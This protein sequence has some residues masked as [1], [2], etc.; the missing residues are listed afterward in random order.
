MEAE[1][2]KRT[3][4][5]VMG[6]RG[7]GKTTVINLLLDQMNPPS[8]RGDISVYTGRLFSDISKEGKVSADLQLDMWEL[9]GG[10]LLKALYPILLTEPAIYLVLVTA[11]TH[12]PDVEV[13]D[14]CR[15]IMYKIN[16]PRIIVILTK[17]N[18]TTCNNANI[19]D[20]CR[21]IKERWNEFI[22]Q[23]CKENTSCDRLTLNAEVI[24]DAETQPALTENNCSLLVYPFNSS[25]TQVLQQ[26][27]TSL[28]ICA[29]GISSDEGYDFSIKPS[30]L[31]T[32]QFIQKKRKEQVLF[33]TKRQFP[34]SDGD[35][36]EK[37]LTYLLKKD[38]V[39]EVQSVPDN[40]TAMVICVDPLAFSNLLVR[41]HLDSGGHVF[42]LEAGKFW[43]PNMDRKPPNPQVLADVLEYLQTNGTVPESFLPLLWKTPYIREDQ[44]L[45]TLGVMESLGLI[46]YAN[47][48]GQ[49]VDPTPDLEMPFFTYLSGSKIRHIMLMN[50]IPEDKPN[51]HWSENPHKGDFQITVH[52]CCPCGMPVGLVLRILA[53]CL[54]ITKPFIKYSYIWRQG[55]LIQ[56]GHEVKVHVQA[57]TNELD[58]TARVVTDSYSDLKTATQVLWMTVA[59]C[60]LNLLRFLTSFPGLSTE[61]YL[62]FR[63]D[64]NFD[65]VF[66]RSSTD[67][68][69]TIDQLISKQLLQTESMSSRWL[70]PFRVDRSVTSFHTWLVFLMAN[71]KDVL[72]MLAPEMLFPPA[73]NT[74][75]GIVSTERGPQKTK[76]KPSKVSWGIE[77]EKT[78]T[79]NNNSVINNIITTNNNSSNN[80]NMMQGTMVKSAP[81]HT[82]AISLSSPELA[83]EKR[84]TH[85]SAGRNPASSS[86]QGTSKEFD[87]Q[88]AFK[89]ASSLSAAVLSASVARFMEE[90]NSASH[91]WSPAQVLAVR[92]IA[93]LSSSV[94][95]GDMT[96]I[97]S[98]ITRAV[99]KSSK[100]DRKVA[101]PDHSPAIQS[102]R[103]C[104]IL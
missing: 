47:S 97:S 13:L 55:V 72:Q 100:R 9:P 71:R 54:N 33:A 70:V 61:A 6:G 62:S 101:K 42:R 75:P 67:R 40:E 102:T 93:Q 8:N 29:S 69:L 39:R 3:R 38:Y 103:F 77:N 34:D 89:V 19:G 37:A 46:C 79:K 14:I 82:E 98:A 63:G 73:S 2:F 74:L 36:T 32:I 41:S 68:R 91:T 65:E 57:F 31:R 51:L 24:C 22:V 80:T 56:L 28:L 52:F 99:A 45:T 11:D 26:L 27:R 86:H 60:L 10:N 23:Y 4:V 1:E 84:S 85:P 59:P 92:E 94:W 43:P 7:Y 48:F 17:A 96:K 88:I 44:I 49:A 21:R 20:L 90:E 58:F 25:D 5:Y 53:L 18:S 66:R 95:D 15:N 12:D 76:R 35:L 83:S 30:L 78:E 104:A 64:P 81:G 16:K 87:E 50:K